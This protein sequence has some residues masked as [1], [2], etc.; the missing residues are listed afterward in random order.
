MLNMLTR[1]FLPVNELML[2]LIAHLSGS[3]HIAMTALPHLIEE[4][5]GDWLVTLAAVHQ[6]THREGA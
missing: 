3:V 1:G 5:R 6:L 2:V 4:G